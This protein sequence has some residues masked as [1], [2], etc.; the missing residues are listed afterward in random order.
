V[1][2]LSTGTIP[3]IIEFILEMGLNA[4]KSRDYA[5]SGCASRSYNF[6][7]KIGGVEFTLTIE[8][9]IK[10]NSETC[11]RVQTGVEIKEVAKYEI[12]CS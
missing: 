6:E 10:E 1:D 2:S 12:V 11:K 9:N 5:D 8:A 3:A 4:K 7:T